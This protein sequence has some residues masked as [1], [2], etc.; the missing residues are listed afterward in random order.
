MKKVPEAGKLVVALVLGA[1]A[2]VVLQ[3]RAAPLGEVSTL[4][5]KLL[6]A[7][8]GP[9]VFFAI[10][11]AFASTRIEGRKGL[12]LLAISF[13]NACVAGGIALVLSNVLPLGKHVGPKAFLG[14]KSVPGEGQGRP[15]GVEL[16]QQLW[17]PKEI[18]L[19]DSHSAPSDRPLRRG[20]RRRASRRQ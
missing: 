5:I 1:L 7:L 17:L 13:L 14:G 2:G 3:E 6:K 18:S 4:I 20:C 11:D 19:T 9:L 12:K 8:A 15:G 16:V 10:L